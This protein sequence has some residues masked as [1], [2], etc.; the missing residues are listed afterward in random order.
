MA[1]IRYIEPFNGHLAE[2]VSAEKARSIQDALDNP[3]DGLSDEQTAYLS[4]IQGVYHSKTRSAIYDEYTASTL[5]NEGV[6]Q[7]KSEMLPRNDR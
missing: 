6:L 4:N 1:F 3:Q 7:G 5:T 2:V